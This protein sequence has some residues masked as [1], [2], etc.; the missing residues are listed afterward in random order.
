MIDNPKF[1]DIKRA[2]GT[3]EFFDYLSGLSDKEQ[4]KI[5]SRI[6]N[7]EEFG[8]QIAQQ[9]QWVAYLDDNL[10]EIR[11][12]VGNSQQREIYFR[13]EQNVY[14]ITHGFIKKTKKTPPKELR[15]AQEVKKRFLK[16]WQKQKGSND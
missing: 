8:I 13:L 15:H 5:L 10:Y 16:D 9:N 11:S 1:E 14:K 6:K 2:D 7:I 3:S 4:A 12:R